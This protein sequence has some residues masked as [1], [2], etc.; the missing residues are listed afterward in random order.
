MRKNSR[1]HKIYEA[2]LAEVC[3]E[4]L[5]LAEYGLVKAFAT[6]IAEATKPKAKKE[7]PPLLFTEK[8]VLQA[9]NYDLQ[10][11]KHGGLNRCL[12]Q[13]VLKEDDLAL[14]TAWFDEVMYPWMRSKEIEFTYSMLV[15]KFPEWLEKSRQHTG[16]VVKTS[17]W[18]V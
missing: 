17:N 4:G 10:V 1:A 12:G 18:V 9:L 6:M 16:A 15:R 3:E 5:T 8:D 7:K 2:G 13:L 11:V 14:F